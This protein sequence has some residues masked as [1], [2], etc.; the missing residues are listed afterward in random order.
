MVE[1]RRK[2]PE[3]F[4]QSIYEVKRG[5]L[6]IILGAVSGSGKTYH[7]LLDGNVLKK[8]SIDVVIGMISP[9]NRPKTIEQ[10]GDLETIRPIEWVENGKVKQDLDIEAI[11]ERNPEV[12]LVDILSHRNRSDAPHKTRLE[13]VIEL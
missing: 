6:K 10:I 4:L 11:K 7:M 2:T 13:D 8:R 9:S 3:E 12:A 1:F 5:R